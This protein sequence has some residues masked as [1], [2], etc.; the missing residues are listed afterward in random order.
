MPGGKGWRHST[1]C[2]QTLGRDSELAKWQSDH[3]LYGGRG[4]TG[5]GTRK[6]DNKSYTFCP[7]QTTLSLHSTFRKPRLDRIHEM[8]GSEKPKLQRFEVEEVGAGMR[9]SESECVSVS[10]GLQRLPWRPCDTYWLWKTLVVFM[11]YIADTMSLHLLPWW[12]PFHSSW[13]LTL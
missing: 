2:W 7:V 5:E 6:R 1:W 4:G 9:S 12:T 3:T 10:R 11:F 8:A 13:L